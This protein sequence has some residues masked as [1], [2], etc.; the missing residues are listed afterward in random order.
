MHVFRAKL[1]MHKALFKKTRQQNN[2]L[3]QSDHKEDNNHC[4]DM[5]ILKIGIACFLFFFY[6]LVK[7]FI[8]NRKESRPSIENPS[9][10][11][12]P[13]K[14][15]RQH[16]NQSESIPQRSALVCPTVRRKSLQLCC[17]LDPKKE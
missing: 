1:G 12:H 7:E 2:S 3:G 10:R 16:L 4:S 17:L 15:T 11:V 8:K 13:M 9:V 5:P 14:S 6:M